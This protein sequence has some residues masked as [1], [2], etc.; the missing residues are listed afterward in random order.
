MEV[1]RRCRGAK[2]AVQR[3]CRCAEVQWSVVQRFSGTEVQR[4]RGAEVQSCRAAVVQWCSGAARAGA[5]MQRFSGGWWCKG[6]EVQRCRGD[7]ENAEVFSEE[8][9]V[10]K[11]RC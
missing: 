8:V 4:C 3:R 6:A 7:A 10:V 9:A 2:L 5:K 1:L 11:Q